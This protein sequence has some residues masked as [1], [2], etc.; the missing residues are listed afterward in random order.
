MHETAK[1]YF[2]L[3]SPASRN[4][5]HRAELARVVLRRGHT[6]NGKMTKAYLKCGA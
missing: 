4:E 1:T 3:L 6:V 5:R 2:R